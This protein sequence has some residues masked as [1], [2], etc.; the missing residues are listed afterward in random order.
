MYDDDVAGEPKSRYGGWKW[1]MFLTLVLLGGG[2]YP[3]R[4]QIAD[5]GQSLFSQFICREWN[6][7]RIMAGFVMGSL[8]L[9]WLPW[10]RRSWK[11][12]WITIGSEQQRQEER[13]RRRSSFLAKAKQFAQRLFLSSLQ[14]LVA[15]GCYGG[16]L[17]VWQ[18]AYAAPPEPTTIP[19]PNVV[20]AEILTKKGGTWHEPL[21]IWVLRL[22]NSDGQLEEKNP[23][24]FFKGL[25]FYQAGEV[26]L[27]RL[28]QVAII[29]PEASSLGIAIL[30]TLS[31][32]L[33][34]SGVYASFKTV[35][36]VTGNH[37]RKKH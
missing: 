8:L 29:S 9:I 32:I 22:I 24:E 35:K 13:Q 2:A 33:A 36:T 1:R 6:A 3:F 15:A 21:N 25:I 26:K 30:V 14:I 37:R 4:Q 28:N 17:W 19:A 12:R 27:D 7:A 16:A 10:V 20:H 5:L 23:D 18:A 31:T 11:G 34:A